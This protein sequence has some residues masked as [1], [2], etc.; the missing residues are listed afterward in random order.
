MDDTRRALLQLLTRAARTG[1][2]LELDGDRVVARGNPGNLRDELR[3]HRDQIR[4]L[5]AGNCANCNATPW[6]HEHATAI[7]WCRPCAGQRG[8][9][10]LRHEHPELLEQE[11][12]R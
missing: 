3:E 4:A 9:A 6:I 10:L 11:A 12:M 8:L 1:L 5:L 2:T 7:P